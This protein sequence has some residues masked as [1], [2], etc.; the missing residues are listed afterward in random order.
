MRLLLIIFATGLF[1]FGRQPLQN[2]KHVNNNKEWVDKKEI[3]LPTVGVK[4][5]GNFTGNGKNEFAIAKRIKKGQGNPVENGT[6]DEYEIQFSSNKMKS[7]NAGCCDILLI[8]EGDLNNDGADE[9]SVYQA[10][11]NGCTYAMTTYTF[12]NKHWKIIVP[13]FLIPTGCENISNDNLQ[14]RIF[15]QNNVIYYYETDPN[16]KHERLVRKKATTK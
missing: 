4:I 13:T 7:I 1:S 9:I 8:N 5:N 3:S 11:M 6:P 12:I 15:K 14:K 2:N 16:D 10:P